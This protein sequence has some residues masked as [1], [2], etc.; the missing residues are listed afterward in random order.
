MTKVNIVRRPRPLLLVVDAF[1]RF[2]HLDRKG[3]IFPGIAFVPAIGAA[4]PAGLADY[5]GFQ[6]IVRRITRS[7]AQV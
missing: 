3:R 5:A 4:D 6:R 2:K 1:H 7:N